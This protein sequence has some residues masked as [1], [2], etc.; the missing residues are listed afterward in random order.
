LWN[1]RYLGVPVGG[2]EEV[3]TRFTGSF[4][5]VWT[6]TAGGQKNPA[7]ASAAAPAG[8]C[9]TNNTPQAGLLACTSNAVVNIGDTT[10]FYATYPVD[11]IRR[12]ASKYTIRTTCPAGMADPSVYCGD[13]FGE[14]NGY[15]GWDRYPVLKK[16]QDNL[17]TGGFNDQ[18]GG[19]VQVIYRLGEVY[20]IA[21]EADVAL[22]NPTEAAQMINVLRTRAASANHKTDP[23]F[24]VTPAQMNLD[25]VMD[26][27][28][29]ELAGEFQRWYDITRPGTAFFLKRAGTFNAKAKPNVVAKHILRPIPQTQIDG[30]VS[31]PKYGQNTG[32]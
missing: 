29:R 25:F 2:P 17:R 7:N 22:N 26:E 3:D 5:Y 21:A 13:N 31:G 27:R 14:N 10:I 15:I 6:A 4:Q 9:P 19:K 1:T 30:V 23:L 24:Q 8:V 32:Y 12:K 28:E 18:N 20:L 11:S 16:F